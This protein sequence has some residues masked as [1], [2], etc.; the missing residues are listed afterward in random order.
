[1][2]FPGSLEQKKIHWG[3][4]TVEQEML[5]AMATATS[6]APDVANASQLPHCS[7]L[8]TAKREDGGS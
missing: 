7:W 4:R 6:A 8:R 2:Q 1:M 5:R 3:E